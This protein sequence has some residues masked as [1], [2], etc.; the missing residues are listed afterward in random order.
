MARRRLGVVLPI[1][2]PARSEIDG[3]RRALGDGALGRIPPHLTLV[4][5]VNVREE[6]V[7][8]ALAVLRAAASATPHTLSVTLG[9]PLSFLPVNPVL[10]LLV[11]GMVD[12]VRALRDR[13]FRPPLERE[14][15]W[16]F[17]PHV[18]LA[19]ESDEDRIADAMSALSDYEID[20]DLGVVQILEERDRRWEAMAEA[21]FGPAPVVARGGLELAMSISAVLDDEAQRFA[22][23]EWD[24][25]DAVEYRV[26]AGPAQPLAITARRSGT[27]VGVARGELNVHTAAAHLSELIVSAAERGTGV[28]GHLLAA[29]EAEARAAG[30]SRLTV[31]ADPQT[32]APAFYRDRGFV[33]E[34]VLPA[35]K[36]GRDFVRLVRVL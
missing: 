23:W 1:P 35:W 15:S 20:V 2:E 30:C 32:G 12:E 31:H 36:F 4:P 5:P 19:D 28:G 27:V 13:V 14:L 25:F 21:R 22:R 33:D 6:Q 34:V 29:V 26:A 24:R 18:T 16:P 9:P 8:E 3:L 7:P 17:V 11:S 10:Y